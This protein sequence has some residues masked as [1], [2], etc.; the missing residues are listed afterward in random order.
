M[1]CLVGVCVI[2][3]LSWR[4]ITEKTLT[5]LEVEDGFV[6]GRKVAHKHSGVFM[7]FPLRLKSPQRSQHIYGSYLQIWWTFS[8]LTTGNQ[9]VHWVHAWWREMI[10]NPT[11]DS[12]VCACLATA[13]YFLEEFW[14]QCC[15][16]KPTDHRDAQP[17]TNRHLYKYKYRSIESI[18]DWLHVVRLIFEEHLQQFYWKYRSN[19]SSCAATVCVLVLLAVTAVSARPGSF[20]SNNMRNT[21]KSIA[22]ELVSLHVVPHRAPF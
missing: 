9:C 12:P 8:K 1:N 4:E 2:K 13:Q 11:R 21:H 19:M 10:G 18:S 6:E 14:C 3:Q 16:W 15:C 22:D 20:I 7:R 5:F 17:H